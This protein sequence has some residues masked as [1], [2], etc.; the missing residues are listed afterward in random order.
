MPVS[1]FD[2]KPVGMKVLEETTSW[3]NQA[4]AHIVHFHSILEWCSEYFLNKIT[5]LIHLLDGEKDTL[6]LKSE[7]YTGYD[8]SPKAI[9][10]ALEHF[11]VKILANSLIKYHT[12]MD[13]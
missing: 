2:V 4:E 10:Y 6:L 3:K 8:I 5:F 13:Y 11:K 9:E 7:N 12:M 1:V